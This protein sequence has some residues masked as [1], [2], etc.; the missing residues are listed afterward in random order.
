[1]PD[2]YVRRSVLRSRSGCSSEK[3]HQLYHGKL[4]RAKGDRPV[5]IPLVKSRDQSLKD[6]RKHVYICAP[7]A[8]WTA[9]IDDVRNV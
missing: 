1:M 2:H 6:P 4:L 8:D 7:D 3:G 5:M 9:V